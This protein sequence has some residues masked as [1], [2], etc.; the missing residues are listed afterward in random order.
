MKGLVIWSQSDC[1]S[2]M[3]LYRAI[4]QHMGVP[5]VAALWFYPRDEKYVTNRDAVGFPRGEFDDVNTIRVGEDYAK[6]LEVL[7]SHRGWLH[8]FTV[9]QGSP[10]WRSLIREAKRRGENVAV[11]CESPCV[12]ENGL[13]GLL[14]RI[15]V[16]FVL[17]RR[18]RNVTRDAEFFVNYSGDDLSPAMAIG[19]KREKIIPFGYF[20]PPLPGS[21][22]VGR[23]GNQDFHIFA[24]GVLTW[25]RG[26]DVLVEAL[27]MLYERGVKYRATITQRGELFEELK[28]KCENNKLPVSFPG[29]L[30][31]EELVRLYES[32]SVYVGAGRSE[33]WGMRL[34]DALQCGAPLVVSTGMGGVKLVRDYNCGLS[35]ENG[36]ATKL[37]DALQLLATDAVEYG[38]IADK[39]A[40]A[41]LTVSPEN[42]AKEFCRLIAEKSKAWAV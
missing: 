4:G 9:Y 19:W 17:P 29:F 40:R 38:K 37:A 1:R 3:G 36:N 16:K 32:C 23:T 22:I 31:M 39:A 15:F 41:A 42:M 12:M 27:R 14:R 20:P 30:E 35:F 25:H 18:V 21:K 7:D 10:V 13:K 11:G 6:G 28:K 24:S 33:P 8:Y 5:M 2:V 34:N 26:A